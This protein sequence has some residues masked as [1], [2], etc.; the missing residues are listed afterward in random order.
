M[1]GIQ[2]W[3]C[4]NNLIM[5]NNIT[6][7]NNGIYLLGGAI[8]NTVH[9]NNFVSNSKQAYSEYL[10]NIWDSGYPSGGNYWNDYLGVDEYGGQYQNETGSDGIGDTPYL[11]DADD[12]DRYPYMKLCG[13]IHDIAITDIIPSK[14]VVG[15]NYSLNVN[16]I[17]TNQGCPTET[18]NVTTYANTTIIETKEVT[19]TS[20]NSATITFTWNTTG[21]A[22]GNYTIS[23]VADTVPGETD[24]EDNTLIGGWVFV[25]IPGDINADG[26]VD[27][28]DAVILSGAAG[29]KP[30]DS[31]WNPNA[32][33]NDDLMIDLFDAVILAGHAGEHYP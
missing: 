16:A 28:F 18:F 11:I 10:G 13:P 14:T 7:N 4:G 15:Q 32:D 26:T 25:R 2:G 24:T 23:A 31:N 1:D 20:G 19:L 30:G 17:L 12:K 3:D 33:I 9:R 21:F 22:Y 8:Y 5:N 29:S 27:V 6:Y